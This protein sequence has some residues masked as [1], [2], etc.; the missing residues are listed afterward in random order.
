MDYNETISYLYKQLPVYQKY[1]ASAIK[2]DLTNIKLLCGHFNNPHLNYPTIHIAGTNGKGTVAHL[3][4]SY[5]QTIGLKVGLYTS[6]HYMDFRERIKVD[7]L[8]VQ[9]DYVVDFVAS[10]KEI[11]S[12]IVPSFFEITVSMAFD[13]FSKSSVDI[14]VIETG[15]GGRLDSTN[16]IEPIL[17]VIT[18]ISLD[19]TDMLGDTIYAIAH[20]KAGIIKQQTPVV[21]GE[22]QTECDAVFLNKALSTKSDIHF[23]SIE[24]QKSQEDSKVAVK[25]ESCEIK[26]DVSSESPFFVSNMITALEAIYVYNEIEEVANNQDAIETAF[27]EYR[28]IS[29]YIGRWQILN[30]APKV[31]TDSAHNYDALDKVI[32]HISGMDY[33]KLHLVLGFVL[34]K[35]VK[36]V[37]KMLPSKATYHFVKP[38]IFR[39][40][41]VA[42]LELLA[43]EEGI[44]GR[45][46]ASVEEAYE[47]VIDIVDKKDLIYIG[48]SS[49]VV[50]D[51][52]DYLANN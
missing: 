29:N 19:H 46:Y 39:G 24:W 52:L 43:Q 51:L 22:Y 5:L 31:I 3:I 42:D 49:F 40:M 47:T 11:I 2:K 17:S 35:D 13:Y 45:T 33:N 21:I 16:I 28:S 37:L 44:K 12:E 38:K 8:W 50:G 4:A 20:E 23:A 36:S 34:G 15:L 10:N 25:K 18:N 14:A 9:Q 27:A 41:P 26:M 1:G 30:E 48:G 6:P 32:Q 7:G